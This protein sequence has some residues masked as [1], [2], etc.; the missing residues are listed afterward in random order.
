MSSNVESLKAMLDVA[1]D[2]GVVLYQGT[3]EASVE[4]IL[5]VQR[6][7]EE[8]KYMP[9]FIVKNDLGEIKEIWYGEVRKRNRY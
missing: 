3:R 6:V 5:Q 8:V 9:D 7:Y 2:Q 1:V 4:D